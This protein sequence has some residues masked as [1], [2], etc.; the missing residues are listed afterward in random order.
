MTRFKSKHGHD[1][2]KNR[3]KAKAE[4]A[5]TLRIIAWSIL[6]FGLSSIA[7]ASYVQLSFNKALREFLPIVG[8][9]TAIDFALF[10][11]FMKT[12]ARAAR[13]ADDARLRGIHRPN[14]IDWD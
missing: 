1:A 9:M 8:L 5:R 4:Q 7:V 13:D 14:V 3:A 2:Q 6:I 11:F 12:A 10:I